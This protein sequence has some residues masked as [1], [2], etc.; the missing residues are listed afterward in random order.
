MGSRI[1]CQDQPS[2]M[3]TLSKQL[4][5]P[6]VDISFLSTFLK[7]DSKSEARLLFQGWAPYI[8]SSAS[9]DWLKW[10]HKTLA[11]YWKSPE[12]IWR[13][14]L[15]SEFPIGSHWTTVYT[16]KTNTY[17]TTPS[18]P[19]L[20]P[21]YFPFL[22]Q[23]FILNTFVNLSPAHWLPPQSVLASTKQGT[24]NFTFYILSFV[25]CFFFLPLNSI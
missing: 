21:P 7:T 15:T 19:L 2:R 18:S 8:R 24:W 1:Y 9:K 5:L 13:V 3:K 10:Q 17:H 23:M 20:K 12:R 16:N 11:Q 4:V 25:T 22:S 14:I 6:L